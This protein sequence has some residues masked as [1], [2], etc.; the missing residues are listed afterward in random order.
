MAMRLYARLTAS[1]D[2][3]LA[4]PNASY[5]ESEDGDEE[6]DARAV[7]RALDDGVARAATRETGWA[8]ARDDIFWRMHRA[9]A[10]I[11][12]AR[13]VLCRRSIRSRRE[14]GFY[15]TRF[16]GH[17]ARARARGASVAMGASARDDPLVSVEWLRARVDDVQILDA[18]WHMP[19][20]KRDGV[21]EHCAR[22]LSATTR[23]FDVDAVSDGANAAP[24]MLPS[25]DAFAA[26][27][28]TLGLTRDR[29]I[30]VYDTN[31]M[32]SA[33]RAWW[34]F[35][36]NGWDDVRVLDGGLPAWTATGLGTDE[37]A[38]DEASVRAPARACAEAMS[39]VETGAKDFKGTREALV[40]TKA[41]MVRN[42][43]DVTYQVVDARGAA[44]FRGETKEP[45]EGVRSGHIP[46]SKNVF[47]GELLNEDKTFKSAE[48]IR[49]AF[50]A[51]GLDLSAD[52]RPIVAS[53]GTGVTAAILALALHRCG[54]ED[55]A[56]YDGSWTEYGA[57]GACPVAAGPP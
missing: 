56:V 55:V 40:K 31:G 45:R 46:G 5:G 35:R 49:R 43:A 28:E 10:R 18:S 24:H 47:F 44:R 23:Y 30:V 15:R 14:T 39:R 20:L 25:A 54:I 6:D 26:A 38:R 34:M 27:C 22:R 11:F 36:A 17:R 50:E 8:R 51:S 37:S 2:A 13:R 4:T 21:A 42:I 32:F 41:E 29:P 12:I 53:C 33:A 48:D 16:E 57:D 3:P 52:A 1:L 7:I 19:N 9:G